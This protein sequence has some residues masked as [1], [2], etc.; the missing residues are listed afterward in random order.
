[1]TV[2]LLRSATHIMV[3]ANLKIGIKLHP[4][5]KNKPTKIDR[6]MGYPN[7]FTKIENMKALIAGRRANTTPDIAKRL[8]VSRR[9][10]LLMIDFIE[11]SGTPIRYC[12]EAKI[13][14]MGCQ[15]GIA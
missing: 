12:R 8:K 6:P 3:L 5:T 10:V 1:M 13:Y 11:K 15:K 14:S 2:C 9:T 7:Y 4:E